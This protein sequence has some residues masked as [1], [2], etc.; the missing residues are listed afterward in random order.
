MSWTKREHDQAVI[1]SFEDEAPMNILI[2]YII[3]DQIKGTFMSTEGDHVTEINASII[4]FSTKLD[5]RQVVNIP[6]SH[7][8]TLKVFHNS[9]AAICLGGPKDYGSHKG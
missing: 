8:T 2:A 5:P 3:F 1:K 7:S 6:S 9:G 4:P